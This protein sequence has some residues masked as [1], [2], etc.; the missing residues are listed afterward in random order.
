MWYNERYIFFAMLIPIL[1]RPLWLPFRYA[2]VFHRLC[3]VQIFS[4][5]FKIFESIFGCLRTNDA[6]RNWNTQIKNTCDKN[7]DSQRKTWGNPWIFLRSEHN[8]LIYE[9][10]S[11]NLIYGLDWIAF[12]FFEK[13]MFNSGIHTFFLKTIKSKRS[14]IYDGNVDDLINVN[15]AIFQW[16]LHKM[17]IKFNESNSRSLT[18]CTVSSILHLDKSHLIYGDIRIRSESKQHCCDSVEFVCWTLTL[19]NTISLTLSLSC[20]YTI[21]AHRISWNTIEA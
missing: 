13:N 21:E 9:Y 18:S 6:C 17:T 10:F 1:Y 19:S 3:V 16:T 8:F 11:I 4:V 14:V 12:F 7:C 5:V 2:L 20:I 15:W